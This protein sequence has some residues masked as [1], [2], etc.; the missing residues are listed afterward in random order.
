M[1]QPRRSDQ[2]GFTL[3]ELLV[4]IAIIAI[5]A[6]ILFPVFA[7]AREKAR[8]ATCLSNEK[9]IGLAF[10]QYVQDYDESF[11]FDHWTGPN[12]N[13]P[14]G[15]W[16]SATYPYMKNGSEWEGVSND[17]ASM[18]SN[19]AGGVYTCPDQLD[20]NQNTYAVNPYV[21]PDGAAPWNSPPN[22]VAAPAI[23]LGE[24]PRPA[25][26]TLIAEVGNNAATWGELKFDGS[27]GDWTNWCGT[28]DSGGNSSNPDL[29]HYDL[30]T[31]YLGAP[32]Y[33]NCDIPVADETKFTGNSGPQFNGSAPWEQYSC[34]LFPRYRHQ[35]ATDMLFV[36]GHVQ[37]M[38]EGSVS[39]CKNIWPGQQTPL[40]KKEYGWEPF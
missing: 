10:L 13:W 9:Q 12:G 30:M 14:Q 19:A 4:V 20:P 27:E 26:L 39:W 29:A 6:A 33:A 37:A 18:Y 40:T 16:A 5:L 15:N 36:D 21:S 38:H 31:N 11:P 23:T 3:I 35:N 7:Q 28:I 2:G 22:T 24:I 32:Y 34:A 25:D 1:R 17:P 8:Q